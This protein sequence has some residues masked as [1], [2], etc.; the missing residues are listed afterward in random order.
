MNKN[1]V[2]GLLAGLLRP[3]Q[4][5]DADEAQALYPCPSNISTTIIG[6]AYPE[7]TAEVQKLVRFAN[8]ADVALYPLSTGNNWGYGGG[9]PVKPHSLIVDMGRFNKII[10][11]DAELGI[12]TIEPGVSQMQLYDFLKDQKADFYVPVTGSNPACSLIGNALERGYGVTPVTDHF[13]GMISLK[14]VLPDGSVYE[15]PA[16]QLAMGKSSDTDMYL[17]GLFSQGNFGIVVSASLNLSPRSETHTVIMFGADK[18]DQVSRFINMSR[19]L[20]LENP[21]VVTSVK[22]FNLAYSVAL[23]EDFPAEEYAKADFNSQ[24]WLERVG[25]EQKLPVW[26]SMVFIGGPDTVVRNMTKIY[27]RKLRPLASHMIVFTPMLINVMKLGRVVL[28]HLPPFKK[29]VSKLESMIALF[30]LMDGKPQGRFLKTAYWRA[31]TFPSE[32]GK[33]NPGRDG[34]GLIWFAP[35]V[36]FRGEDLLRFDDI[37]RGVCERHKFIPVISVTTISDR[38]LSALVPILFDPKNPGEAERAHACYA[39]L[40]AVCQKSGYLPYRGHVHHLDRYTNPA[41]SKFWNATQILKEKLDPNKIMAP[42]RYDGVPA[43]PKKVNS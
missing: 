31:G 21:N 26:M 15:G 2:T 33:A 22:F 28:R 41:D 14:S 23:N 43:E 18:V 30:D 8:D 6:V 24:A 16:H 29:L 11:F 36:P 3:D 38:A 35:I 1:S 13:A 37:V 40:F 32:P 10:S 42:G 17:K 34:A 12:V 19:Q 20:L 5:R 39:E 7:T 25:Q 27:K 9:H 4:V